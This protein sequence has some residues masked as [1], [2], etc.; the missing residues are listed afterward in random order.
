MLVVSNRP[1][2][3]RASVLEFEITCAISPW[4][5]LHSVQLLL[6]ITASQENKIYKVPQVLTEI[7][8]VT[9]LKFQ[10]SNQAESCGAN[11]K[12][13]PGGKDATIERKDFSWF[14]SCSLHWFDFFFCTTAYTGCSITGNVQGRNG[15]QG[16]KKVREFYFGLGK[17]VFMK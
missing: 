10:F 1:R 6:L 13:T 17:N 15:F 16:Q 4:I 12:I 8:C 7:N 14:W 2:V 3:S 9:Q 11:S 5:V